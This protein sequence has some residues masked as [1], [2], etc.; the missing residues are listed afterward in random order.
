MTNC[1]E[2]L[3]PRRCPVC[4]EPVRF[5]HP[6]ICPECEKRLARIGEL[7]CECCG[8]GIADW[9]APKC[10]SC[11]RIPHSFARGAVTFSYQTTQ[12]SIFRYKYGGRREYADYYASQMALRVREVFGDECFDLMIPVP[13]SEEKRKKRGFNQ[14]ELLAEKMSPLLAVPVR[15]DLL[16]RKKDT[17]PLKDQSFFARRKSLGD[18]F[19]INRLSY[20]YDVKLKTILLVDDVFTTGATIDACADVLLEEGVS[21]V[22]FVVLSSYSEEE[23]RPETEDLVR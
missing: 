16:Q 19:V 4:D 7:S 21:K 22:C 15:S 23:I 8:R 3:L 14:A 2:L 6:L 12:Q 1:A 9:T 20:D 18:A 11:G 13:L 5:P 10:R 17:A